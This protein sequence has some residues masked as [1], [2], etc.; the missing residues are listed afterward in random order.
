MHEAAV[1]VDVSAD[2]E[3]VWSALTTSDELARWFWPWDPHVDL[4][5]VPGAA[6]SI[7]A[8]HPEAGRLAVDGRIL[9]VDRPTRLSL[10]W[11]WTDEP[12]PPTDVELRL[13]P[14]G[15]GTHVLVRHRRIASEQTAADYRQAWI[16]LLG[17]L[18]AYVDAPTSAPASPAGGGG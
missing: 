15:A 11:R 18:A 12:L 7:E 5:P 16:D 6:W 14:L 17:R 3:R 1:E 9:G 13:T 8:H 10:S 4:V 2:V